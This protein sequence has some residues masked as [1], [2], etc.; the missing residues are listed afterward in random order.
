MSLEPEKELFI[1]KDLIINDKGGIIVKDRGAGLIINDENHNKKEEF[2]LLQ[3]DFE[4]VFTKDNEK[5]IESKSADLLLTFLDLVLVNTVVLFCVVGVWRGLFELV[6]YY[7]ET[8]QL[9]FIYFIGSIIHVQFALERDTYEKF[10]SKK[11]NVFFFLLKIL[12]NYSFGA[13]CIMQWAG[14]WFWVDKILGMELLY[15]VSTTLFGAVILIFLKV[16]R[17]VL[18]PPFAVSTDIPPY[19]FQFQTMFKKSLQLDKV[20]YKIFFFCFSSFC[21]VLSG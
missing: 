9:M 7:C 19:M 14:L 10:F 6:L 5:I 12:Y 3:F 15:T 8:Y 16:F 21:P 2:S 11:S 1:R 20:Q 13:A 4:S 18:A 17:N